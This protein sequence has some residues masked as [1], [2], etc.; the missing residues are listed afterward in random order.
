ME[1]YKKYLKYKNKYLELKKYSLQIHHGGDLPYIADI[2]KINLFTEPEMEKLLNPIYGYI[3]YACGYI[4]NL[5]YLF[6][7]KLIETDSPLSNKGRIINKMCKESDGTIRPTNIIMKLKPIDFGRFIAI[8]YLNS[9]HNFTNITKKGTE[10]IFTNKKKEYEQNMQQKLEEYI[11]NFDYYIKVYTEHNEE[12]FHL[13]LYCFWWNCNDDNGIKQYYEGINEVIQ[14]FNDNFDLDK[15]EIININY[16]PDKYEF[17][18]LVFQLLKEDF[19][20]YNQESAKNF[21][22]SFHG[23]YADC[24][25]TTSR[26]LINVLCYNGIQFDVK[27]LHKI[28]DSKNKKNPKLIEY[29]KKFNTFISQKSKSVTNIYENELNARDA[30]SYLIIKHAQEKIKFIKTCSDISGNTIR[31]EITSGMAEEGNKS[32][33]LQLISNLIGIEKW[34]DLKNDQITNIEYIEDNTINGIGNIQLYHETLGNIIIHCQQSHYYME[35]KKEYKKIESDTLAFCDEQKNKINILK[36]IVDVNNYLKIDYSSELLEQHFNGTELSDNIKIWLLK[37][38]MTKKYD[39][40]LRRRLKVDVDTE[41]F[42]TSL[43]LLNNSE[44]V[45]VYKFE[46]KNFDFIKRLPNLKNLNINFTDK[47]ITQIVLSDLPNITIIGENFMY[48]CTSLTE[49]NLSGLTNLTTI[50]EKFMS[51]CTSLIKINLSGLTNL[52]T[53]GN[54]FMSFC[55]SLTE[56]NLSGLTNLTTIRA[57]FMSNCISLTKINLSGLTNLTTIGEYFMYNCTSL[58]E[59]DLSGLTKL[60]TIRENFMSA[61]TSLTKINLSGLTNLTTIGENF[62]SACTSLT[63]IN[64]SGLTKLTTIGEDFMSNCTSLTE[65]DLSGL[66]KLTTIGEDFMS[67]CTSLTEIDLSGLTKLTTIPKN[68]MYDCT[69]LTEIDLSGLTKLTSIGENF[70]YGCKG[71]KNIDLSGLTKLTSIGENFMS[72]CTSLE[73]MMVIDELYIYDEKVR[74]VL[75]NK[76]KEIENY[77]TW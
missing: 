37:L 9:K 46:C 5:Y 50:R 65:I 7:A 54:I 10:H 64:L 71:L 52:T 77:S 43:N 57:N 14:I 25:E 8:K 3:M 15:Y 51:G 49:I 24:G 66:T 47:T 33:F 74:T 18:N 38:S 56:I 6:N 45:N 44:H 40:D 35:I 55:T 31:F 68:F 62:M 2:N 32:N 73:K 34:E 11:K 75:L 39:D 67:N 26:N 58:T 63:K 69:R 27:L 36:K 1:F 28:L 21:C 30:W 16:V 48:D 4:Y 72:G 19:I 22:F 60:T 53:I 59:I 76:Q 41:L 42:N 20:I 61:C 12:Y 29:Y 17:E 23:E 70:M 13:I